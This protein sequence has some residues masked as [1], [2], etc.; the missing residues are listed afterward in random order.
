M[1]MWFQDYKDEIKKYCLLNKLDFDKINKYPKSWNSEL[2]AI[3]YSD[4]DYTN[5]RGLLDDTP[6]PLVL[7]INKEENGI[8]FEQTEYTK[9]YAALE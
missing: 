3:Q 6:M 1:E 9:L 7:L 2:I 8:S 4:G 5:T